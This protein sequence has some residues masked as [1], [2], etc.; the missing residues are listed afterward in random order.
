MSSNEIETNGV[1]RSRLAEQGPSSIRCSRQR[2]IDC[3][4][5]NLLS[6]VRE[7]SGLAKRIT[8]HGVLFIE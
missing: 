1:N 8:L 5:A 3:R 2:N 4:H 7:E 6:L